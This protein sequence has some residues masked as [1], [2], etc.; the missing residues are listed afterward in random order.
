MAAKDFL[1]LTTQLHIIKNTFLIQEK[2]CGYSQNHT[3]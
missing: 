2:G 3:K 1:S